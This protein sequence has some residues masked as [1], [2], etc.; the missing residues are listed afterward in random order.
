M[1][2][3]FTLCTTRL[4]PRHGNESKPSIRAYRNNN[5]TEETLEWKLNLVSSRSAKCMFENGLCV[6]IESVFVD[7]HQHISFM[8]MLD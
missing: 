3:H 7:L 8:R 5:L 6:V 2:P 4:I 1:Q